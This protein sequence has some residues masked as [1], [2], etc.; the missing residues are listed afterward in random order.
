MLCYAVIPTTAR[1]YI[2]LPPGVVVDPL[3]I[4]LSL[5]APSCAANGAFN[6]FRKANLVL[7]ARLE[8]LGHP[9]LDLTQFSFS[10]QQR[11]AW[12]RELQHLQQQP[13]SRR[14]GYRGGKA[15]SSARS[16]LVDADI[17]FTPHRS[18]RGRGRGNSSSGSTLAWSRLHNSST[19]SSLVERQTSSCSGPAAAPHTASSQLSSEAEAAA[20]GP[21]EVP[22]VSE[23][24]LA[25]CSAV[26]AGTTGESVPPCSSDGLAVQAP[27]AC[28]QATSEQHTASGAS[29]PSSSL[30]GCP[31]LANTAVAAPATWRSSTSSGGEAAARLQQQLAGPRDS[32][33]VAVLS[34]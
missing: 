4:L 12:Q 5:W 23:A 34:R 22:S 28:L 24:D 17:C 13:A 2:A 6:L 9:G 19:S 7:N 16:T 1:A 3:K 26:S 15:A 21:K 32:G 33:R 14:G 20:A 8:S 29:S 10:L 31:G 11:E 18:S 30:S 25:S 27:A